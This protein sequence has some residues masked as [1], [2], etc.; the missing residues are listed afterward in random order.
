[1]GSLLCGL[2]II[3]PVHR[4]SRPVFQK[5]SE[6]LSRHIRHWW[7]VSARREMIWRMH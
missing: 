6:K 3:W 5:Y 7:I 1:M 4:I 2:A